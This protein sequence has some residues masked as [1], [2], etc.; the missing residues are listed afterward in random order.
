MFQDKLIKDFRLILFVS[1]VIGKL[2]HSLKRA[3]IPTG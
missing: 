2:G 3:Q 1:S